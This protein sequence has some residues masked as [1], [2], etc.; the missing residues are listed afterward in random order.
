[1]PTELAG[2]TLTPN[3]SFV[4]GGT[5]TGGGVTATQKTIKIT[6]NAEIVGD[7]NVAAQHLSIPVYLYYKKALT[8]S[9]TAET[10]TLEISKGSDE[11]SLVHTIKVYTGGYFC[12]VSFNQNGSYSTAN[13]TGIYSA[14]ITYTDSEMQLLPLIKLKA[15]ENNFGRI[16]LESPTTIVYGDL[17]V[18]NGTL[19][20][21]NG[22]GTQCTL[23]PSGITAISITATS[24]ES[25]QGID[26]YGKCN[27]MG[28][29][30]TN[31]N[32]TLTQGTINSAG[33]I[34]TDGNLYANGTA[35]QLGH[36]FAENNVYATA[37][38][39]SSDHRLKDNIKSLTLNEKYDKLF[40]SLNPVEFNF[41][42]SPE[43]IHLGFI[44]QEV[45]AACQEYFTDA[46][47]PLLV[48]TK[49]PEH[50]NINYLEIIALNTLQ[51]QKLKQQ[52]NELT[53]AYSELKSKVN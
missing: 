37:F 49:N 21:H 33:N 9:P 2:T 5:G 51:I 18:N 38:F 44:A 45:E 36:V 42:K 30:D 27:L 48:D 24:I 43:D 40:D 50:Y 22:S 3:V 12:G 26:V 52:V 19:R 8:S 14:D 4:G 25:T 47:K 34:S 6:L 10:V 41:K 16:T 28:N 31:G 35:E 1:M 53:K 46:D 32:I 17:N 20:L 11:Y 29:I 23:T 7:S 39:A 15:N 13:T